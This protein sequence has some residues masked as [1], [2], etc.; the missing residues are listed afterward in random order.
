MSPS[1]DR[2]LL[3]RKVSVSD[4]ALVEPT[5]RSQVFFRSERLVIP[6]E[7]GN[8]VFETHFLADPNISV[9]PSV[10]KDDVVKALEDLRDRDPLDL[11][12]F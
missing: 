7:L 10:H 4:G 5:P 6:T 1:D 9:N 11:N 3:P 8:L 2:D 12:G